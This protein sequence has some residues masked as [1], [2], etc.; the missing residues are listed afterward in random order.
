[1]RGNRIEEFAA[2]Q[3]RFVADASHEL[4]S[5]LTTIRA[6]ADL[7][8]GESLHEAGIRSVQRI[9]TERRSS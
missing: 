7:L 5:Q 9:R 6:N 2:A 8:D 1:M 3:R 4:R